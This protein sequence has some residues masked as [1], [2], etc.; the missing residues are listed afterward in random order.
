VLH[1]AARPPGP[2]V[3][4][5][6]GPR[7]AWDRLTW[8]ARRAGF[9][10]ERE[11]CGHGDGVTLWHR[12]II[13]VRPGLD[14]AAAVS[15]LAHELGHVRLH[16]PVTCPPGSSTAGCSGVQHVEAA[17]V[18]FV[19]CASL[20]LDAGG[21]AFPH[22]ASWAGSDERARPAGAIRAATGRIVTAASLIARHLSQE[23]PAEAARPA[24]SVWGRASPGGRPRGTPRH[25]RP[26]RHSAHSRGHHAPR[27]PGA[28]H[29]L[30]SR[31]NGVPR[32][33]R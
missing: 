15:A 33:S 14:A 30:R 24:A 31:Q 19:V 25:A 23:L 6:A 8:L 21:F 5:G 12:R 17:S 2:G 26:G 10:V 18:A 1:A 13:R 22:V 28:P 32:G 16:R 11:H 7:E 9:A 4:G 29:A 20:G 27:Q 3:S